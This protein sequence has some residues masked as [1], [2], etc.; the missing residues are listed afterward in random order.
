MDPFAGESADRAEQ[1]QTA[2]TAA[3]LGIVAMLLG[4]LAC[5]SSGMTTLAAL[6]LGLIAVSMARRADEEGPSP[7]GEAKAYIHVAKMTGWMATIY[8]GIVILMVIAYIALYVVLFGAI[9]AAGI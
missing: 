6:P 7:E 9:F 4:M 1:N 2:Q 8:S 3:M 5:C